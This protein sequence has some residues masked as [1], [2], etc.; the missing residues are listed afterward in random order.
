ML[1]RIHIVY[2]TRVSNNHPARETPEVAEKIILTTFFKT[3]L[4]EVSPYK[5]S[6]RIVNLGLMRMSLLKSVYVINFC[7]RTGRI[8]WTGQILLFPD[9]S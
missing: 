8:Q 6:K 3:D 7:L 9:L 2:V 5:I 1:K 4:S